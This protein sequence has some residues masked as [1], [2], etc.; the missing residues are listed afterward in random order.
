MAGQGERQQVDR[1]YGMRF[2]GVVKNSREPGA[3]G[4]QSQQWISSQEAQS[5]A[6]SRIEGESCQ[7]PGETRKDGA[8]GER[9]EANL[10]RPGRKAADSA[11]G[12]QSQAR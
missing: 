2:P 3:D 11:P 6:S 7:E 4:G 5:Q 9:I 10:G 12:S 8:N 1:C